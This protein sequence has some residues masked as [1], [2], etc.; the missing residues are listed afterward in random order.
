MLSDEMLVEQ[1]LKGDI[2]AFEQ[3]VERYKNIVFS[4]AYKII[5]Q[6]QEAE[7]ISQE[8]FITV[9]KKL[10]QFDKAK[11]FGPWIYKIAINNSIT[12]IRKK[13]KTINLIFDENIAQEN[14]N[15]IHNNSSNPQ[16]LIEQSEL[17]S[18]INSAIQELPD[19]YRLLII[20]RFHLELN[21]QEIADILGIKKENVEV[22]IHRARKALRNI[23]E[24][25]LDIRGMQ[26][27]LP[28]SR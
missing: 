15:Y 7:D 4:A 28:R 12:Y 2:N 5:G 11:K 26:S 21:N 10:Y 25:N 14:D 20:M 16:I 19:N 18:A 6:Y 13:K 3:L 24:K 9:Y 23:L 1:I 8:V 22:K 27:E 17:N